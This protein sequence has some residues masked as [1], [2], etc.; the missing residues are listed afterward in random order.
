MKK[1]DLR[2]QSP[3][4]ADKG[5][6]CFGFYST[7]SPMSCF[8]RLSDLLNQAS[9]FLDCYF[10]SVQSPLFYW[11]IFFSRGAE[12]RVHRKSS[13]IDFNKFLEK[14]KC[15]ITTQ[16]LLTYKKSQLGIFCG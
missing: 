15:L 3:I 5:Y 11:Q 4:C 7:V 10:Y 13:A 2:P 16:K 6:A 1:C 8:P 12:K 14:D 9:Y